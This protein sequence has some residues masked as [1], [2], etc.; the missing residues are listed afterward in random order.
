MRTRLEAVVMIFYGMERITSIVDSANADDL[1]KFLPGFSPRQLERP[2]ECVILISQANASLMPSRKC[3]ID[4]LVL[5]DGP[6]GIV[7]SGSHKDL[8]EKSVN[9]A[10]SSAQHLVFSLRACSVGLNSNNQ[11]STLYVCDL[12]VC[13]LETPN[14]NKSLNLH[15]NVRDIVKMFKYD[16]IGAACTPRCG[17]CKCGNCP[18][19]NKHM[20]LK[21]E[22]ELIQIE[23]CLTF[24]VSSHI[25]M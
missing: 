12:E 2:F 11:I 18:P 25:G 8:N 7:V 13:A 3:T 24:I 5:W 19:G 4:N 10:Q 16:Q 9:Y 17:S 22:N 21:E 6:M 1:V 15:T 23:T 20:T 14:I